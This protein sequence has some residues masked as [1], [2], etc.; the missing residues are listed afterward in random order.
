MLDEG[1]CWNDDGDDDGLIGSKVCVAM[2]LRCEDDVV[3]DIVAD[4]V[5]DAVVVV[6]VDSVV[7]VVVS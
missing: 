6:V 1:C 7:V 3:G 2:R 4:V 5:V